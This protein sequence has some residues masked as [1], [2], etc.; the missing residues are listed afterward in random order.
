MAK[1]LILSGAGISAES[2]ISTFRDSGGLWDEY[3]VSVVCNYDS[4]QKHEDLTIEFYDKRRAELQ[5]KEPNYAHKIVAG[6]KKRYGDDIA[7]ITQNVDN[8]FEKAGLK[9][10]D[11]IHLHGFMTQLRCQDSYC[12]KIFDVG[13]ASQ[14]ELNG[15]KCPACGSKLRPNIVFFGEEA[16]MYEELNRHI[17]DCE[18]FVVIGT[19]GNV[20]GVNTMAQFASRSI[21]NNY[22]PS[23]AINDAYFSKVL[24]KKATEAVDEIAQEIESFL[25]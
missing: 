6:L 4:M 5:T 1:V 12:E 19:S 15:G 7:V 18:L 10:E 25:S 22:E 24:Y 8:L 20:I 3:D 23:S 9:S 11:V 21:L 13:Y 14:R 16:P 17:Q 2:G